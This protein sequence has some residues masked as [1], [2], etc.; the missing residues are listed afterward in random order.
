MNWHIAEGHW[1]RFKGMM[2]MSWGSLSDRPGELTAGR[3]LEHAGRT[4]LNYGRA[5]DE[6]DQQLKRFR[7]RIRQQEDRKPS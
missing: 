3:R 5:K 7:M 2:L 4:Q 6:A 1:K